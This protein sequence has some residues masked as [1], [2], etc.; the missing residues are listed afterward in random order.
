MGPLSWQTMATVPHHPGRT[1]E[2][3]GR[4]RSGLSNLRQLPGLLICVLM[5]MLGTAGAAKATTASG[6]LP[7]ACAESRIQV[8]RQQGSDDWIGSVAIAARGPVWVEVETDEWH[9]DLVV[10][11]RTPLG[12][13]FSDL[14]PGRYARE[15]TG[16][17][18]WGQDVV[19]LRVFP[20]DMAISTVPTLRVRCMPL[21]EATTA[22]SM[23]WAAAAHAQYLS[24]TLPDSGARDAWRRTAHRWID[25]ALP[26]ASSPVPR[27][28][29]SNMRAVLLERAGLYAPAL[30]AYRESAEAWDAA[31]D[32]LRSNNMRAHAARAVFYMGEPRKAVEALQPLLGTEVRRAYPM[33]WAWASN[34]HCMVIEATHPE[35]ATPCFATLVAALEVAGDIRD[36][37][38]S[39]CNQGLVF[40]RQERWQ[41]AQK[42]IERCAALR[43]R[44][45]SASGTA[46][47]NLLLGW[48]ALT[49]GDTDLAISRLQRSLDAA[50]RTGD[51]ARIWDA[52]RWLAQAW[53]DADELPRARA[54]LDGLR[55]RREHDPRRFGFW[56]SARGYVALL[57]ED[58][59][60]AR[61]RFASAVRVL[62]TLDQQLHAKRVRC[63]W[64][65]ID[66][67]VRL[68]DDCE[69]LL[70]AQAALARG[71]VK[72]A[73]R[74]AAG[75]VATGYPQMLQ[76]LLLLLTDR[77]ISPE[78]AR[79]LL[80]DAVHGTAADRDVGIARQAFLARLG[81]ELGRRAL[82]DRDPELASI[83]LQ[84][85]LR[86]DGGRSMVAQSMLVARSPDV[87]NQPPLA[88]QPVAKV[89]LPPGTVL[90]ASASTAGTTLLMA[91]QASGPILG[92]EIDSSRLRAALA[93]LRKREGLTREALAEIASLLSLE[94]L[95]PAEHRQLLLHVHGDL[96]RLPWAALPIPGE[97]VTGLAYR[98]LIE[99]MTV[100]HIVDIDATA[101]ATSNRDIGILGLAAAA[102]LPGVLAE[103]KAISAFAHRH[104][105][106]LHDAEDT[107]HPA[108][109]ILHI[110]MHGRADFLHKTGGEVSLREGQGWAPLQWPQAAI[111]GAG[112]VVLATCESAD[113][114]ASRWQG[115]Y[116]L[117]QRALRDGAH[118][119]LAHLW[120]V[121]DR[122]AAGL[123]TSFYE[124]RLAGASAAS[125]LAQA[126]RRQMRRI[127]A[128]SISDWSSAILIRRGLAPETGASAMAALHIHRG[129][130]RHGSK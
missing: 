112:L 54:T 82:R 55:P 23:A 46:Q 14:P 127:G 30:A 47:A 19:R 110:G 88:A 75:E 97:P 66:P 5:S 115:N 69:P 87:L 53:L 70:G 64:A 109:G 72:L 50:N 85:M 130:N 95:V 57:E 62:D 40:G 27:A 83:A 114:A 8:V 79:R 42:A 113:G 100:E 84:S 33:V 28:A 67:S 22:L 10:A 107:L 98:P 91:A 90:L 45:G 52:R 126:Q 89:Q 77:E 73:R 103:T 111:R 92:V 80:H 122:Q 44:T 120:P 123:H 41:Q 13:V 32:G 129:E 20:L 125:A 117:A 39:L 58:L 59:V 96:S 35:A 48:L 26:L 118:A 34:D 43:E 17:V 2:L 74:F 104:D 105:W 51:V 16:T 76:R 119:V 99:A 128:Q 3:F 6:G 9:E 93:P 108:L 101:S 124:N 102:G 18:M 38:N 37:A 61:R 116:S 65:V 1:R 81:F 4:A 78:A 121:N 71:D 106:K 15:H 63:Q 21:R 25:R 49:G 60:T 56:E 94:T 86:S 68:A 7:P 36:L 29:L 31:G 24:V 12:E 11:L